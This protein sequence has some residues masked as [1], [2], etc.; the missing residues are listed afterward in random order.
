MKKI[1]QT[2]DI[3][4]YFKV[5][6]FVL[7]C[8]ID[9]NDSTHTISFL[10]GGQTAVR[11]SDQEN[12]WT[13][14][15]QHRV[16]LHCLKGPV[17]AEHGPLWLGPWSSPCCGCACALD[18]IPGSPMVPAD[19]WSGAPTS[20]PRADVGLSSSTQVMLWS[21]GTSWL[22]MVFWPLWEWPCIS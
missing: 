20:S 16:P 17:T 21:Q 1:T 22:E 7:G 6:C 2:N 12:T 11:L 4:G 9:Q 15:A 5:K 8:F 19:E 14:S 10:P 3:K 18:H 13:H